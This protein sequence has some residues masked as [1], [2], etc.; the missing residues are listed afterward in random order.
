MLGGL[1]W[2]D[3]ALAASGI[4]ARHRTASNGLGI[5]FSAGNVG[6]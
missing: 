2:K 6:K 5:R 1:N 4:A 3:W